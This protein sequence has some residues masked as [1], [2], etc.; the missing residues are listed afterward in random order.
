MSEISR[1]NI[2]AIELLLDNGAAT[3]IET[4]DGDTALTIAIEEGRQNMVEMVCGLGADVS[5]MNR[6]GDTPM[7]VAKYFGDEEI[8]KILRK[9]G[10]EETDKITRREKVEIA[11]FG[12]E[13]S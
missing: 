2:A 3:D 7:A 8:I 5:Y 11:A 6:H 4:V 1:G 9:Y 13:N 12:D 10:A